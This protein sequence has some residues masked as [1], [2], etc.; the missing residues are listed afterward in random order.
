MRR[1][2]RIILNALTVLSLMLCVGTIAMWV[3][4]DDWV[5]VSR[6]S[7]QVVRQANGILFYDRIRFDKWE[8]EADSPRPL[9]AQFVEKAAQAPMMS[10]MPDQWIERVHRVAGVEAFRFAGTINF[11][12]GGLVKRKN[13]S[14]FAEVQY[15]SYVEPIH[16]VHLGVPCYLLVLVASILPIGRLVI[17][18]TAWHRGH[19]RNGGGRCSACGY[20]LRATPDRC[21]ECGTIPTAK[22]ARPGGAGG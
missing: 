1:L 20:D 15:Q 21:P 3:H 5:V 10:R 17:R 11:Y 22:A 18:A 13:A 12:T 2:H 4:G 14:P 9:W 16:A 6:P 19:N 7:V 8:S